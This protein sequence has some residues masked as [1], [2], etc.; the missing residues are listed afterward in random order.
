MKRLETPDMPVQ[1]SKIRPELVIRESCKSIT[2][3]E[4]K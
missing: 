4:I 1:V 2:E 3:K